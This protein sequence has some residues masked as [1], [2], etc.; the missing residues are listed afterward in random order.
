VTY[1]TSPGHFVEFVKAIGGGPAP[2]SN[3]ADYAGPLTE[4][5]LL[6]NLAIWANGKKIEW[7]AK[8][9]KARNAPEVAVLIKPPYR[10]GYSL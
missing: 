7:N 6:G 2:M 5:V 8:E 3:F 9:L 10:K 4:T 1:P